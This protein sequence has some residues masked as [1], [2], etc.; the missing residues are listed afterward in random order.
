MRFSIVLKPK[1]GR[2]G[3]LRYTMPHSYQSLKTFKQGLK[4]FSLIRLFADFFFYY[5]FIANEKTTK[6]HLNSL[7]KL[8][9]QLCVA[10][11]HF[12]KP[13]LIKHVLLV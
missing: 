7:F 3:V 12:V 13:S 1:G 10:E 4:L 9:I 11:F 6:T 5:E 2:G 8:V